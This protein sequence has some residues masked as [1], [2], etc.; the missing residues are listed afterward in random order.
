VSEQKVSQQGARNKSP[1]SIT[2]G[3]DKIAA[4]AAGHFLLFVLSPS[5]PAAE[6]MTLSPTPR[7][8]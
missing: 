5:L 2:Q 1:V 8:L 7:Q 3:A 4:T 6:K